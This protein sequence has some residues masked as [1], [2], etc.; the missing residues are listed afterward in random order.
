M[1]GTTSTTTHTRR[2][3]LPV[4]MLDELIHTA[5]N[6]Y[7]CSDPTCP[8]QRDRTRPQEASSDRIVRA[9]LNESQ[10]FQFWR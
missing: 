6:G 3:P 7:S 4:L 1:K 2:E 9:S 10:G 8:C 5:Q